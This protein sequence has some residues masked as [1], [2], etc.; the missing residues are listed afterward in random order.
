[1]LLY[2]MPGPPNAILMLLYTTPLCRW[3]SQGYRSGRAAA[4]GLWIS[5]A[6]PERFWQQT[7]K[8][9]NGSKFS[10]IERHSCQNELQLQSYKNN[11]YYVYI[12]SI[13]IGFAVHLSKL[14]LIEVGDPV[15]P[16]KPGWGE[17]FVSGAGRERRRGPTFAWRRWSSWW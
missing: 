3:F 5:G 6:D 14:A 16:S 13:C 4:H 11:T 8:N 2:T 1:M 9:T 7:W 17:S 10:V 12:I 15:K